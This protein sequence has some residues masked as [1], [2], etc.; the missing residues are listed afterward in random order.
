MAAEFDDVYRSKF[1]VLTTFT[2]DGRPKPTPVRGTPD[3]GKLLVF[4]GGDSWKVKRVR[5]NSHVTI[6]ACTR[7]GRLTSDG[8]DAEAT[9][10]PPSET[11]R[12]Y[13]TRLKQHG[14][15]GAA[16]YRIFTRLGG[17]LDNRLVLEVSPPPAT[18]S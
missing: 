10:L 8:A 16:L 2:K 3:N 17:G 7:W 11:L 5:N 15:V 9:V 1:I 18:S 12:V 14:V 6:A 4:T 13:H